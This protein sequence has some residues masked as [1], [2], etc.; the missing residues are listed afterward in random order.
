MRQPVR[1]SKEIYM[2]TLSLLIVDLCAQKMGLADYKI[3][4]YLHSIAD[5]TPDRKVSQSIQQIAEATGLSWRTVQE[6]LKDLETHGVIDVLSTD[7]EKTLIQ[8]PPQ[9]WFSP[10]PA[11]VVEPPDNKP[12]LTFQQPASILELIYRLTGQRP[13]DKELAH[14]R[15]VA[16][17]DDERLRYCLDS[18]LLDIQRGQHNG[19]ETVDFLTVAVQHELSRNFFDY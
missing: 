10:V 16:G 2:K 12:K 8:I 1:F 15:T 7:K 19:W 14:M 13:S 3:A 17:N 5:S 18:F 4:S 9:R 6:K 11:P